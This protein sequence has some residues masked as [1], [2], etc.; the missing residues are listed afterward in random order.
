MS[1]AIAQPHAETARPNLARLLKGLTWGFCL[2]LVAGTWGFVIQQIAFERRVAVDDAIRQNV[3]RTIAFE[4]YVRRTLEAADLVTRYVGGRFAR[5]DVGTEFNGTADRPARITGNVARNGTFIGVSIVDTH[6][7]IVATSVT[8]PLPRTNVADHPAFRVHVAR[9]SGVLYVSPPLPSQFL[10]QNLIWL[11]RR[12]NRPDGSFA[13]VIAINILPNQFTAF[14][15]D[16][17]VNPM[18]V[19]SVIGLD[20]IVRA[21]RVGQVSSSGEDFRGRPF[22]ERQMRN[23]SGTYLGRSAADGVARYYSQRRLSDYPLFVAYGVPESEVLASSRHRARI[24]LAGAALLSLMLVAFAVLLTVLLDRRERREAEMAQANRRLREAQRI[25]QIG[26]W[27]YDVQTR[28]LGWSPQIFAMYERDPALGSPSFEELQAYL[29]DDGK[30]AL[31]RALGDAVRTGENQEYEY[32]LRLPSGTESHHQG[33]AIPTFDASGKVVRLH[34]TDQNISARKLL[35]LLQ[36]HV[37]HLSRIEAMNAMA[38]TLAHELNQP[39]TAASNYLVGSRRRLKSGAPEEIEQGMMAAEQQVHLAADI[40]RRVREMVS[41]PPRAVAAVAL[42]RIVDD[43]IALLSVATV[44]PALS[45]NKTI[46]VDAKTVKGDRI[47]IQQVM[48][49]LI[50]NACDATRG[51]ADP[52]ITIS[53]RRSDAATVTITVSD[54]G[55]GFSQPDGARFSPFATTKASGLGLGLSISR[56]IIESHGGRIWTEDREGEGARVCFTLPAPSPRRAG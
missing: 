35:D 54:N 9:D 25:G 49:N 2:L 45:V 33:V 30:A 42:S 7:D 17:Q 22:M 50:R 18:D 31:T 48:V 23:P 34:G 15:R 16:A 46:A 5:G 3:N 41:N 32:A 56:T 44:Y 40:I 1:S 6:G 38:A 27:D 43:A 4:Q 47:Q 11:S 36:T 28:K 39:L 12:L 20:G 52:E 53:S 10:G 19:M 21:R 14:Y 51:R 29:D 37:A 13:G 55:P 26:D 8:L 24:F